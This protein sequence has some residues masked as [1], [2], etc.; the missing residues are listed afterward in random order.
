VG[1]LPE[2]SPAGTVPS[3]TEVV[4]RCLAAYSMWE[5]Q[6][7]AFSWMDPDSVRKGA[8]QLDA[9]APGT[10][11]R[12]HG[13]PIGVKDLIDTAG[14][15]TEY[16]SPV[17]SGRVPERNAPVVKRLL[18]SGAIVFGKTV[19]AELAYFHPGVTTNPW[20]P[21]RTPG[22]SSMGSAAAVGAGV[23][24]AAVGTQTNGSVIRP[25][26]FC[27][28]VGFKPTAGRLPTDGVLQFS[29]ALDQLGVFALNVTRTALLAAIMAGD[30]PGDWGGEDSIVPPPK[31]AVVR[32]PEWNDAEPAA[33]A[34]FESDIRAARVA[35][36]EVSELEMPRQL[37]DALS[38]H[39]TIMAAEAYRFVGPLVAAAR[40]RVS[41]QLLALLD[42]G[43]AITAAGYDVALRAQSDLRRLFQEWAGGV[44]AIFTLPVLG[45][46]PSVAT[47]GD[48]RCCTRWTLIGAPA[49]TLPTGFGPNRLPLGVQLVGHFD[50]D[51]DL[52]R[53]ARWFESLR[54]GAG[55]TAPWA[56]R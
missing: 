43:G 45:E 23:I 18:E 50:R 34:H 11:G 10:R 33:R 28:I 17:F 19:T 46:A 31:L 7:R 41:R 9:I 13:L 15:P 25:A 14:I 2:Q 37:T 39:R 54:P 51:S 42:E 32:T 1:Q 48:P 35:G 24:P 36:A 20:N 8:Q 55:Q 6:L 49:L 56:R 30:P 12:L 5:P 22:G 44:D 53:A 47:T 16:G 21:D 52:I 38:V 40:D 27:G 4:E 29:P 3:T 26:A